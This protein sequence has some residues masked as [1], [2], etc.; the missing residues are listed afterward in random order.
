MIVI[1]FYV[2]P[3]ITS[4]GRLLP[5]GWGSIGREGGG[6]GHYGVL[7]CFLFRFCRASPVRVF[8]I[9]AVIFLLKN[10][11]FVRYSIYFCCVYFVFTAFPWHFSLAFRARSGAIGFNLSLLILNAIFN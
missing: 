9:G 6:A 7:F 10:V 11:C 1:A 3:F 2:V 5:E 8:I 4:W